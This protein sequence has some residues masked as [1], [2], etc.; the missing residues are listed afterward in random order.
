[1]L[2]ISGQA[3]TLEQVASVASGHIQTVLSDQAPRAMQASRQV[4]EDLIAEGRVVYGVNTGF[5]KLSDVHIPPGELELLQLNLVRSHSCGV[6]DPLPEIETRA[7]MLLRANVL[8]LGNS[9]CR[10]ELV[11]ALLD[12]LDRGVHPLIPE[13]G[14]VGA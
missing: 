11:E 2:E 10:V 6:G 5:G 8:A 3:L 14:S 9:G 13:K 1:M 4:I 7:M 12:M